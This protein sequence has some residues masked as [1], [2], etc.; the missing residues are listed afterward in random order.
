MGIIKNIFF[1]IIILTVITIRNIPKLQHFCLMTKEIPVSNMKEP[2]SR[3]ERCG[4]HDSI[5]Q[6]STIIS[7]EGISVYIIT[8]IVIYEIAL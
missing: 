8:E 3:R 7:M 5:F 2:A 4:N 1:L 6:K